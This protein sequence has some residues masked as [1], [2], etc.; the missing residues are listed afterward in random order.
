ML[1]GK[2]YA[3]WCLVILCL[4]AAGGCSAPDRRIT[5]IHFRPP[6]DTS[7]VYFLEKIGLLGAPSRTIDSSHVPVDRQEIIFR[8]PTDV[9]ALYHIRARTARQQLS[10]IPDGHSIVIDAR[11]ILKPP[12]IQGSAA[13]ASLAG[14]LYAKNRQAVTLRKLLRELRDTADMGKQLIEEQV[15]ATRHSMDRLALTYCDTVSNP[16]GFLFVYND[17]NFDESPASRSQMKSLLAKAARR[18]PKTQY[19]LE[20]QKQALAM[21]SIFEQEFQ[22]GDELPVFQLQDTSGNFF[23]TAKLKGQLY[24]LDF[25]SP[26]CTSCARYRQP[27]T[28]LRRQIS[29]SRLAMVSVALSDSAK[30]QFNAW[31]TY[32]RTTPWQQLIDTMMWRGPAAQTLKF[33][34]IPFNFLVSPQGRILAKA[35]PADSLVQ[36]IKQAMKRR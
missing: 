16:A 18:F 23:S 7:E 11:E 22:V 9:S 29:E 1:D 21:I 33:D 27:E 6:G 14:Y 32:A 13:T 15:N 17:I 30:E 3:G 26:W 4:L 31:R 12:R 28:M 25:W 36:V 5:T 8:V 10:V 2:K 34:S 24:F 19:V 20:L 35:I